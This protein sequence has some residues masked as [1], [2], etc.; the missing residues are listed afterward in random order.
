MSATRAWNAAEATEIIAQY[1]DTKGAMLPM[2]HALQDAFGY[3]DEEAIPLVA[4]ALNVSRA[5]VHGVIT[6]YH[7]FHTAPGGTHVLKVCRA[8]ACQSMGCESLVDHLEKSLGVTL[9]GT[10]KDGGVTLQA[11]YC[12]GNCALSP[13][14]MLNGKLYGRVSPQRAEQLLANARRRA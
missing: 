9:G 8:E 2:L 10:T 1:R 12:L 6:F 5:E 14:A 13:A 3:V 11:V 4:E 7:D